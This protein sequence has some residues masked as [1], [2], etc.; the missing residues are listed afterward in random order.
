MPVNLPGAR[1]FRS[2]LDE[3]ANIPA[4]HFNLTPDQGVGLAV[5][6]GRLFQ[7]HT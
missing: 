5:E 4:P 3:V 2:A 1:R 6:F 7:R